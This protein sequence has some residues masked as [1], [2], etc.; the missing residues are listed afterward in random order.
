MMGST[1]PS[2]E[3]GWILSYIASTRTGKQR[4]HEY[5]NGEEGVQAEVQMQ[6]P[7]SVAADP[8]AEGFGGQD[9]KLVL[10]LTLAGLG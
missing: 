2:S 8:G 5:K 4:T 7:Q 10:T 1:W 9:S 3:T 6:K